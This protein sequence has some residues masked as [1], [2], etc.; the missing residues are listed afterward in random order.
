VILEFLYFYFLQILPQTVT[1]ACFTMKSRKMKYRSVLKRGDIPAARD[2][3][4]QHY[5]RL[6]VTVLISFITTAVFLYPEKFLL[7]SY[8]FSYLGARNSPQGIRNIYSRLVFDLGMLLCGYTMYLLARYYHSRHPVPDSQV[9]EL[10]CRISAIGF[11]LMVVPCDLPEVTFLH[12]FGSGFVVGSHL[13]M[14]TIRVVAVSHQ[15]RPAVTMILLT[16]LIVSVLLYAVFWFFKLPNHPLMQKPAF[17]AII[18]V[19]L[20][21]SSLSRYY[22][23]HAVFRLI[24][25]GQLH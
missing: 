7:G 16:T 21:G 15:I 3:S 9:Y 14:A 13:F 10:L 8:P 11:I 22:G 24:R 19:E 23:E 12:S 4:T 17:A 20:Y 1:G 2:L 18:Y 25:S 6:L 5:L